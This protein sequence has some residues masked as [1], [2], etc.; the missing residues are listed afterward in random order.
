MY[1]PWP[2]GWP[3][4]CGNRSLT[5]EYGGNPGLI[6]VRAQGEAALRP[7]KPRGCVAEIRPAL[8]S[9]SRAPKEMCAQTS[10]SRAR[11]GGR[12]GGMKA[13]LRQFLRNLTPDPTTS[14]AEANESAHIFCLPGGW[15]QCCSSD[16]VTKTESKTLS[17]TK[18][19]NHSNTMDGKTESRSFF[20][21]PKRWPKTC[22]NTAFM[23]WPC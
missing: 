5:T 19:S 18:I 22:Q 11:H 21:H 12:S 14:S 16:Y 2:Q 3:A 15:T 23:R 4:V 20:D 8:A 10:S 6:G 7:K 1:A 9:F 13:F 17:E